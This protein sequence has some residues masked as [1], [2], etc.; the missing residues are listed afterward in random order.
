VKINPELCR[1]ATHGSFCQFCRPMTKFFVYLLIFTNQTFRESNIVSSFAL[2]RSIE[3][4]PTTIAALDIL[5]FMRARNQNR[6]TIRIM[7]IYV[8][9]NQQISITDGRKIKNRKEVL[10]ELAR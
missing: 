1:D 8:D 5:N 9:N 3:R 7:Y 4:Q 2:V 6:G 10:Q